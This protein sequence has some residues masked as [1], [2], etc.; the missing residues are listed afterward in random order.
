MLIGMVY[1]SVMYS[2]YY[3]NEAYNYYTCMIETM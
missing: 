3:F 1:S 2:P